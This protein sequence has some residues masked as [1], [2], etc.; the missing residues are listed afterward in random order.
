MHSPFVRLRGL[1]KGLLCIMKKEVNTM[2][3]HLKELEEEHLLSV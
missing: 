2:N 1:L 3:R